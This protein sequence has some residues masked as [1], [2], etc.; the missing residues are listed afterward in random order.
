MRTWTARAPQNN[1]N[2]AQQQQKQQQAA[3]QQQQAAAAAR[4]LPPGKAAAEPH[5]RQWRRQRSAVQPY[6]R[7][8][9]HTHTHTPMHARRAGGGSQ[10]FAILS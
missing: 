2:K 9:M 5:T 10:R 3:W 8:R 4:G 1:N 7:A 6:R